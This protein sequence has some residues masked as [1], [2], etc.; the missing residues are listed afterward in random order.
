MTVYHHD[1]HRVMCD[2]GTETVKRFVEAKEVVTREVDG[3]DVEMLRVPISST[4]SDRE[5]DRFAK[6]GLEG[7]AEQ[8][9]EEQPMVFDNH[10]LAG[11]WMEAIP[12]DSRETIGAQMDADVEQADDGEYELY[13]YINPDGTHPEGERMLEQ[14]AEEDQPLKY[15]VGFR[16][17]AYDEIQDDAGNE[18]GREF[19]EADLMETSR[20]GIPANSDASATQDMSAAKN[21]TDLPGFKN[22]PLFRALMADDE[23]GGGAVS[24]TPDADAAK[25]EGGCES[26]EDCPDG[27]VC[28]EGECIPEDE[29]DADGDGEDKQETCPQCG[30]EVPGDA[31][32]CPNCG[33]ELGDP[34]D[35]GD[36]DEESESAEKPEHVR[37]ME[38]EIEDLR[39]EIREY[40]EAAATERGDPETGDTSMTDTASEYDDED[41]DT[42]STEPE[43]TAEGDA[44]K[45]LTERFN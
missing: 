6:A 3:D 23:A 30:E 34:G 43:N 42:E 41:T 20:V 4:R 28:V 35:D 16:V 19:T 17:L 37:E 45:P 15:S 31:N 29:L 22:H 11:N 7:M 27:E 2:G 14:V 18:I 40:R 38:A 1:G 12:Y 8:I 39:S 33:E 32:Y 10:G 36:D 5:G 25:V 13:A 21:V 24:K 44:G 26:D 9:R